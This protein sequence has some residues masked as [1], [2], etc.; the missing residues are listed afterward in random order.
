MLAKKVFLMKF[1]TNKPAGYQQ[2]VTRGINKNAR[3]NSSSAVEWTLVAQSSV[4][5]SCKR[6]ISLKLY[7]LNKT[8]VLLR[9]WSPTT[10]NAA[11]LGEMPHDRR[12]SLLVS[13][14]KTRS[15]K[16]RPPLDRPFEGDPI[17]MRNRVQ[18]SSDYVVQISLL[19]GDGVFTICCNWYPKVP[20]ACELKA[21]Q[22]QLKAVTEP[23]WE[24]AA[25]YGGQKG[26]TYG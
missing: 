24:A 13:L 5:L 7:D 11:G 23:F 2:N 19:D 17:I 26:T 21:F 8:H 14:R 4:S 10:P 15:K 18:L 12:L 25:Q 1:I 6:T 16:M 9:E 22:G 3:K 20:T